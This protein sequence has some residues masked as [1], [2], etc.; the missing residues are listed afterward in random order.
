MEIGG[1][2]PIPSDVDLDGTNLKLNQILTGKGRLPDT[3]VGPLFQMFRLNSSNGKVRDH[4]PM[5]RLS[6]DSDA[7]G[8]ADI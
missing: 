5:S 7:I 2:P 3:V 4:C 8:K 6:H 1:R